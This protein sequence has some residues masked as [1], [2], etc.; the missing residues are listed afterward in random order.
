MKKWLRGST[1]DEFVAICRS[2][3]LPSYTAKQL[4]GWVYDKRVAT[5]DEM[6]NLSKAARQVLLEQ[7]EVGG[8]NAREMQ[9]SADGTRKYLFPTLNGTPIETVMIPDAERA[10]LCVSCQSG[11]RW[12]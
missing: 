7:F 4:A 1:L 2:L 6:S 9:Q 5:I 12:T 10:T 8:F 3:S 11:C